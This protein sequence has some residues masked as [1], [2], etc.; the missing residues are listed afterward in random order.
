MYSK[1]QV[2]WTRAEKERIQRALELGCAICGHDNHGSKLEVHHLLDGGKRMGHNFT[3]VLC[4]YHHQKRGLPYYPKSVSLVD[5]SKAFT[6]AYGTQR[7]LFE[8]TQRRLGLECNWPASKIVP[9]LRLISN[10]DDWA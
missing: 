8:S 9:R 4:L 6:Q 5:G 2:G 3:I 10:L 7:S 1:N